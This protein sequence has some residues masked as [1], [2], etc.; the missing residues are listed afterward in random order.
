MDEFTHL[1][2]Q[3]KNKR[4]VL[5]RKQQCLNVY[6]TATLSFFGINLPVVLSGLYQAKLNKK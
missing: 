1:G 4:E 3:G 2:E 5:I 6:I